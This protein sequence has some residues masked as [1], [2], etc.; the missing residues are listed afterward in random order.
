[1]APAKQI[2][3]K[4]KSTGNL[5]QQQNQPV[6][7]SLQVAA[8][9]AAFG[10]RSN[11]ARGVLSRD[12]SSISTKAK[13]TM[14]VVPPSKLVAPATGKENDGIRVVGKDAAKKETAVVP[15]VRRNSHLNLP[16][17]KATHLPGQPKR[18][19]V[20]ADL[21]RPDDAIE[22][23]S[24]NLES[25]RGLVIPSSP[26]PA[27]IPTPEDEKPHHCHEKSQNN[28]PLGIT[29]SDDGVAEPPYLDA[30]EELPV[31]VINYPVL[32][33]KPLS[34]IP[35]SY[36]PD[37][38]PA[39]KVSAKTVDF[40]ALDLLSHIPDEDP[41]YSSEPD[42]DLYD[43]QGYTTAHSVRDQDEPTALNDH[44]DPTRSSSTAT[45][46]VMFPPKL[47]KKGLAELEAA[48]GFVEAKRA[49]EDFDE[50]LWD[51]SMVAEYS[52]EIFEYMRK[53]EVSQDFIP[54]SLLSSVKLTRS[55]FNCCPSRI[56]WTSR[57]RSSGQCEL[58]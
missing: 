53:M 18:T 24:S 41:A 43:D 47:G 11:T 45:L 31:E 55:R 19:T 1:M 56:T 28:L 38:E 50:D 17:K 40:T 54:N 12:D 21:P 49:Y 10:D 37:P 44:T 23:A 42:E 15:V 16:S 51:I 39:V 36:L 46:T 9:R 57:A 8:K 20:Y 30:V 14:A 13:G 32:E 52:T 2:H 3:H 6:N 27:A 26:E 7:G 33:A 25:L 34:L 5:L 4:H 58:S 29:H 35:L 48:K 22:N